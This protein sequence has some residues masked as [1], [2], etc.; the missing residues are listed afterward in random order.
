MDG[1]SALI[2]GVARAA[3]CSRP[4]TRG[5]LDDAV[6]QQQCVSVLWY[7]NEHRSPRAARRGPASGYRRPDRRVHPDRGRDINRRRN[8]RH[9]RN[10]RPRGRV[11]LAP[12]LDA[13]TA[14]TATYAPDDALRF[15]QA[16][17]FAT[18]DGATPTVTRVAFL[19]ASAVS[20]LL[21][22]VAVGND[23]AR[24]VCYVRVEG[25]LDMSH[26][27]HPALAGPFQP[28][29]VGDLIFD[30]KTGNL[31]IAGFDG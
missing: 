9:R 31:L 20:A 30:A 29:H 2:V 5:C 18:T 15:A 22:G 6:R 4:T 12:T 17:P 1:E 8:E 21:G 27:S 25:A 13:A 26:E 11:A 19:P 24:L 23:P 3:G 28:A 7:P 14:L 10:P 16:H